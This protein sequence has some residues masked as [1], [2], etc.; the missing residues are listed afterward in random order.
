ME[1]EDIENLLEYHGFSIKQFKG[2]YMMKESPFL[3][4]VVDYPT[5]CSH[6][7]HMKK[8]ATIID[9]VFSGQPFS[10][11]R[12]RKVTIDRLDDYTQ[13]DGGQSPVEME[14]F[15]DAVDEDMPDFEDN[16]SPS[17][18][19]NVQLVLETPNGPRGENHSEMADLYFLPVDSFGY[20]LQPVELGTVNKPSID[21]IIESSREK[22]IYS[23]R[24]ALL[25]QS[26]IGRLFQNE[27][28]MVERAAPKLSTKD[29]ENEAMMLCQKDEAAAA[30]LR[31]MLRFDVE[32][33][34]T[35][36]KG[37]SRTTPV[38]S[39]CCTE[40]TQVGH[41]ADLNINHVVMERLDRHTKS[42][43]TMNVSEV[44][45]GMLGEK[46]CNTKCICWKLIVSS[47]SNEIER[48]EMLKNQADD[49]SARWLL[50][51]V[52]GARNEDDDELAVSSPGL[53]I[54]KK[55]A[56]NRQ[57]C[58]LSVIR[59]ISFDGNRQVATD[60]MV[61][62]AGAILFLASENIPWD[63]Q[64]ARLHNLLSSIPSGSGLP[65][66]VLIGGVHHNQV[67]NPSRDIV[68]R[69]GLHDVD[70]RRIATFS[71]VDLAGNHASEDQKGFLSDS[72]LREGLQWLANQSPAQLVLHEVEIR[73]LVLGHLG[74]SLEVL[75]SMELSKVG[76]DHCI[77]AFNDALDR[78][79][80]DI[81]TAANLNS[82]HWPSP[83][84]NLLD[85]F[86]DER[87][88]ADFLLPSIGWSS[89]ERIESTISTLKGCRLPYF[90]TDLSWL[91]QGSDMGK[92]ILNQ[93]LKLET[94]L[95]WYLLEASKMMG[96][97]LAARE[98]HVMLQ[99]GAGVEVDGFRYHIVPRWT[100]IFRR[101]F[102]WRIMNLREGPF[103][104][105]YIV[106]H[107]SGPSRRPLN[108]GDVFTDMKGGMNESDVRLDTSSAHYI[109]T[110]LSLDEMVEI[111]CQPPFGRPPR[112]STAK[113]VVAEVSE[114][115]TS[116]R[117]E[118]V[119]VGHSPT[120]GRQN[121]T[122]AGV[123]L[124]TQETDKLSMLLE[125]CNMLQD[126]ID[127]KLAVYF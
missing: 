61:A 82:A 19:N 91:S 124:K 45:M 22:T 7:V 97:E 86:S 123:V 56:Y 32:A 49:V 33:A 118:N 111:S 25:P 72:H 34:F 81:V 105:A 2:A 107:P 28:P 104:R 120:F 74:Y 14:T 93:K 42:W 76:P 44:V 6:L 24:N 115:T 99:K 9:D 90:A 73:E 125:Q 77:S 98:A 55:W 47:Q 31:L 60:D 58:C 88:A 112:S 113:K 84:I 66:L 40:F 48:Q 62:G 119:E 70:N 127:E 101:V 67:P 13:K 54:W 78:S 18:E 103:S 4:S 50:A 21:A 92:D 27:T 63:L 69:L 10:W 117:P 108:L 38:G 1:E 102:N 35:K 30:K 46:N 75:N 12:E 68:N 8:S 52:M 110:N 23:P 65:L 11:S 3:N 79:S 116:D 96:E 36:T 53:S 29:N 17:I 100:A 64:R 121:E 106:E 95:T 57:A 94:C 43:S 59:H 122:N 114:T 71:I 80:E 5:K 20:H 15:V 41:A 51:K 89:T 83:E 39:K 37:D 109:H 87:R 126:K 85:E 16:S 26:A